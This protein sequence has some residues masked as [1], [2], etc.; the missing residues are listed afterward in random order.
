M[1]LPV[2]DVIDVLHREIELIFVMLALAAI[3]GA[4]VGE[5]AQQ[6][7]IVPFKEREH[8]IVQH[9]GR[10]QRIL[11]I[12][13]LRKRHLSIGVDEGLLINPANAFDSADVIGILGAQVAGMRGFDLAMGFFSYSSLKP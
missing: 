10:H 5:N 2:S 9:V 6:R 13:Q 3:F 4:A 12:V 1:I 8:P 7:N 11:A